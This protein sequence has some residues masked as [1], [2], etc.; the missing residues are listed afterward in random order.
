MP[1]RLPLTGIAADL[2]G[3]AALQLEIMLGEATRTDSR[4]FTHAVTG[5]GVAKIILSADGAAHGLEIEASEGK[6]TILRFED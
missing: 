6:T 5:A 2:R 4:H 1:Y 3:D